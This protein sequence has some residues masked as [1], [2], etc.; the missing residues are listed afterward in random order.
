MH[1]PLLKH[2]AVLGNADGYEVRQRAYLCEVRCVVLLGGLAIM[3][4]SHLK[5]EPS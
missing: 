1:F 4:R 3:P 2:G 5:R